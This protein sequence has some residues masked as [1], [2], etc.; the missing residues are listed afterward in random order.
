MTIPNR[1]YFAPVQQHCHFLSSI[2]ANF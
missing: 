2:E 1:E